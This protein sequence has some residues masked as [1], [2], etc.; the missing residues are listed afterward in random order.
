MVE[1]VR[2]LS[3]RDT[4][5]SYYNP[6]RQCLEHF[7]FPEIFLRKTKKAY[8]SFVTPSMLELAVGIPTAISYN[9]I[10]VACRKC[11]MNMD[12]HFCRR[13]FASH[14]R[15]E[16]GIQPEVVDMLQGRVSQSVL[17]RHYMT[18]SQDLKDRVLSSLDK[19]NQAISQ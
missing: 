4:Y 1:S 7:R 11:G 19:L 12:M 5:L 10:R 14:L 16:G 6:E 13:I 8:I 18:P 17:T 15:K 3:G 2:L 9:A